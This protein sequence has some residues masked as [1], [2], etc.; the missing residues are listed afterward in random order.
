M[1]VPTRNGVIALW[2]V[3]LL[4]VVTLASGQYSQL[5]RLEDPYVVSG[6]D[7]GFRIEGYLGETLAGRL[8]IRIDGEWVEPKMTSDLQIVPVR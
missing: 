3:F 8:V 4:T 1:T 2:L 6:D 7:I 5:D